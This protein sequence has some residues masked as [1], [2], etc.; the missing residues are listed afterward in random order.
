M[1]KYIITRVDVL[2]IEKELAT[3]EAGANEYVDKSIEEGKSYR[4]KV[5]AVGKFEGFLSEDAFSNSVSVG[6]YRDN[7]GRVNVAYSKSAKF[8]HGIQAAYPEYLAVDDDNATFTVNNNK[9]PTASSPEWFEID[10]AGMYKIDEIW[11]LPRGRY[12]QRC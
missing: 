9:V 3:L 8:Q 4:Y 10:L 7:T 6:E 12:G 1:E 5:V 11:I 2:G